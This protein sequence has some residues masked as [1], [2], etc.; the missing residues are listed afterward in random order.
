VLP[1]AAA[2][3][4]PLPEADEA[5]LD[6]L[7]RAAFDY[8]V[9][10]GQ[11]SNGLVADTSRPGSHASIAVIGFALSA[12]PVG[13]ERG[14]MTRD[15]ALL[16]CLVTLRFFG[17]SDQSGKA[18]STGYLGFYFHFLH[19]ASGSR[20]WKCE[21]SLIDTALLLAGMLTAAAYFTAATAD[22]AELRTRVDTLYR[23]VDWCWAQPDGAAVVHGWKP[24]SGFLN[25]GW[26]GYSEA[27]LLYALGL[28]SPTHTLTDASFPAW[29]GTYQWENLYGIDFLFAGP[30]FIHQFSH[31]WIDFRGIRD[32]F[33]REKDCDYFENSRRATCVQREYAIR[34]PRSF[35][36]YDEAGWGLSAGDGPSTQR[37]RVAGRR[38]SFYGYAARG[39]PWGP[40]DGTLNG[41]SMLSS[42]VFAPELVLPALR[43]LM[44]RAGPPDGEL[45]RASGYNETVRMAPPAVGAAKGP[46]AT[47][48]VSEGSFGLDQ[49][50]IV[51]MVENFRSG[52]LW[53]LL[54]DSPPIR[55]GLHR[56]G[57]RGGW[58]AAVTSR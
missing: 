28:G 43:K 21:V 49:G 20:A 23:R 16:R 18:D 46:R 5:M 14:W 2:A 31:A 48:W 7:Q 9:Q 24:G 22:E 6:V 51:L 17:D 50:M 53:R 33:M 55:A 38:Q 13:V 45:A 1:P 15:E 40:D 57:F 27:L 35:T 52:M 19:I 10:Y 42:L 39:V 29:T 54:R 34:N 11:R 26:E 56:A 3:T 32:G 47:G 41:P 12:Y 30:L 37:Q 4:E 44:A 8:F 36:G 58:L 25:Y